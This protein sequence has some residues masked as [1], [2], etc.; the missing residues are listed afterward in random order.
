MIEGAK[1]TLISKIFFSQFFIGSI[2][3]Y[4]NQNRNGAIDSDL[5]VSVRLWIGSGR[6]SVGRLCVDWSGSLYCNMT[7]Q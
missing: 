6:G 7:I 5:S 4:V 1:N 3:P 2:L